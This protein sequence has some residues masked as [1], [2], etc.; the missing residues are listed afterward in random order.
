MD[1]PQDLPLKDGGHMFFNKDIWG[2][3][4]DKLVYHF[5]SYQKFKQ[6]KGRY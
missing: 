6:G 1:C 4:L 3:L 2:I 5:A